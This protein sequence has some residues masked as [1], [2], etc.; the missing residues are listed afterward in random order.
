MRSASASF[1]TMGPGIGSPIFRPPEGTEG[2]FEQAATIRTANTIIAC[3]PLMSASDP[4]SIEQRVH[5]PGQETPEPGIRATRAT[6]TFRD[7]IRR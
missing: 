5:P 4:L 6:Q 7:M 3:E 2:V 1:T